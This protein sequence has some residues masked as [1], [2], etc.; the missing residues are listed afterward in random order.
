MVTWNSTG[1]KSLTTAPMCYVMEKKSLESLDSLKGTRKFHTKEIGY[2]CSKNDKMHELG[3]LIR[4]RSEICTPSE[5][6]IPNLCQFDH[7]Q[8]P[9][10]NDYY[11]GLLRNRARSIRFLYSPSPNPRWRSRNSDMLQ[12]QVIPPIV[13][14]VL[15]SSV[16]HMGSREYIK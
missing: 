6:L 11:F 16:I 9:L 7:H 2:C 12:N 8:C 14:S 10:Q 15:H 3:C 5:S 1:L 4:K 13:M